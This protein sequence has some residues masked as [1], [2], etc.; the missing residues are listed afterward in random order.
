MN[1]SVTP[2]TVVTVMISQNTRPMASQSPQ[3]RY[4]CTPNIVKMKST[5]NER[6]PLVRTKAGIGLWGEYFDNTLS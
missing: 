3:A 4:I 6:N 1:E 2:T 5:M